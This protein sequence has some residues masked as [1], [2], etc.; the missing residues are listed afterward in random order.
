MKTLKH[1][2]FLLSLLMLLPACYQAQQ[3]DYSQWYQRES[4]DEPEPEELS[5]L[6]IMSSNVRYYSARYKTDDPDV[7]DRDWE[8]RKVGYFEMVNTMKPMVMGVQEAEMIQV[9]D[10][11]AN[12]KGYSYIGVGRKDGKTNGE[13][14]SIIYRTNEVQV[15]NWGTVWLSP[16]PDVPG[17]H[18]PEMTDNQCRTATWAV[19]TVKENG[20][21]FFYLNTHTS[22]Y[23]ASQPKEIQVILNTV[24]EKCPAGLPV[25]LSADWNLEEDDPFMAPVNQAYASA[26]QTAPLTD[27]IE[28]FHWWGNKSTISKHQHLDHIFWSGF[29]SCL[30]FRTLN[31]KWR[32]YWISDHHPVYAVFK[33]KEGSEEKT[34]PVADFEIP[35]NP[36]MDETIK[37]TDK[38]TSYDGIEVWQWNIGGILSS[39]QNPEVVFNTFGDNIPVSLTVTDHYGQKSTASKTFS[40]ARSEGHDLSVAWS[41]AYDYTSGAWVNWTSPALNPAGDRIYVTS[42]GNH[43]VCFDPSGN[44]IGSYDLAENNPANGD[45]KAVRTTPSVDNDGTV[46]IPVQYGYS[47]SGNGGLYSIKPDCAGKNWYCFTGPKAQYEYDIAAHVGD[48]VV[49]LMRGNGGNITDNASLIK[50]SDGTEYQSLIC[51]RGS[52]GG[53]AV[54]Y[55]NRFV[56]SA[57]TVASTGLGAGYKVAVP[58][59]NSWVT[60]E[61]SNNG[62]RT[63]ML[64]GIGIEAKGCQPAISTKDGT[65]Y[66]CASLKQ[67]KNSETKVDCARYDLNSYAHGS[68]PTPIWRVELDADFP[69]HEI[70]DKPYKHGIGFGCALD[71]QGNAYYNV[72]DK[73]FRLNKDDG[74]TAWVHSY[75]KGGVGVPAIDAMGY[76]YFLDV[77]AHS[78]V[79]LSTADGKVISELPLGSSVEASSCPTIGPDGSI[80]FNAN[81]DEVPTLYKVTCPKTTAPGSNWSQLGGNY[82][83]TCNLQTSN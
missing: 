78:L 70:D 7:G 39:E 10:I 52:Y 36:K 71:D 37:F 51:D 3:L 12:C 64:S 4:G 24:T 29:E 62:R 18:F 8:V 46:Y 34:K 22:L 15:E 79:K 58:D 32:G 68:S 43:L 31:M 53:I 6:L 35:E 30:R 47:E 14:T 9:T 49:V 66:L 50:K 82:Q 77:A 67:D 80:Y 81:V 25:V 1:A 19:M 61:N 56:Y 2:A 28:T 41:R 60:S 16:T 63:N 13:S 55:N 26:R 76:L 75:T 23:E 40:V 65:V 27:N 21:R 33:F 5:G 57:I 42:S 69:A 74:T 11:L 73:I 38:S 20:R 48:Y 54:G 44:Q 83:K 59:G 17:S 45:M 72:G